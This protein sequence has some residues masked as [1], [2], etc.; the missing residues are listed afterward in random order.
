MLPYFYSVCKASLFL[1]SSTLY[2]S[3]IHHLGPLPQLPPADSAKLSAR[4]RIKQLVPESS[5][6]RQKERDMA[7]AIGT[8]PVFN[9]LNFKHNSTSFKLILESN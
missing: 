8:A 3:N 7:A 6:I 2:C 4:D 5:D 9:F 1:T